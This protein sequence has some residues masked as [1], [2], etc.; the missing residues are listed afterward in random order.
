MAKSTLRMFATLLLLTG[1]GWLTGALPWPLANTPPLQSA[2]QQLPQL[3]TDTANALGAELAPT[4]DVAFV[5]TVNADD[6]LADDAAVEDGEP[7]FGLL[8][9][10]SFDDDLDASDDGEISSDVRG[11]AP[12]M[13]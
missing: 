4:N 12:P 9:D 1:V 13:A 2:N 8:D 6:L 3:N 10:D 11:A 5:E 7:A